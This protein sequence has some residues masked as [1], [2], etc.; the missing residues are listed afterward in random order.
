M[1]YQSDFVVIYSTL[2]AFYHIIERLHYEKGCIL[3]KSLSID[4]EMIVFINTIH[5][6]VVVAM[7]S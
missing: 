1:P 5:R 6:S 7:L 4:I 3:T 2:S